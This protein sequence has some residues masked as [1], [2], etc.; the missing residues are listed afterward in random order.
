ME[1]S[2]EGYEVLDLIASSGMGKVYRARK[3][4]LDRPVAIKVMHPHMARD[5]SFVARFEREARAA[6]QVRHE[7]VVN[8]EDFGNVN[9]LPYLV[10]EFVEGKD[11]DELIA[12]AGAPPLELAC[13]VIL[14][15]CNGLEQIHRK[16]VVHR[17]L[18][19][20]NIMLSVTG[21]AKITDFGL[22]KPM[23][24]GDSDLT[25]VG[26]RLG[27]PAYM[28]PEQATSGGLVGQVSDVFSM[29]SVAY[30]LFAGKLAFPGE[31][32][33]TIMRMVAQREPEPLRSA[34]PEVPAELEALVTRMMEKDPGARFQEI[35]E[36]VR[37]LEGFMRSVGLH[38]DRRYMSRYVKDPGSARR[39][40]TGR[41]VVRPRG[42]GAPGKGPAPREPIAEDHDPEPVPIEPPEKTLRPKPP[43]SRAG[44][45]HHD[46]RTVVR[47]PGAE[48]EPPPQ[49]PEPKA[50]TGKGRPPAREPSEGATVFY[51]PGEG[52]PRGR[53]AERIRVEE[54]R[55]PGRLKHWL[56][57][58][59][60]VL[61]VVAA[62]LVIWRLV[63]RE[64]VSVVNEQPTS[65]GFL[66][67]QDEY[68]IP[69]GHRFQLTVQAEDPAG[70][71]LEYSLEDAPPGAV[72]GGRSGTFSWKPEA[73]Q[74][75]GHRLRF[76][77]SNGDE[78]AGREVEFLVS[79]ELARRLD[80][81]T[82]EI[83]TFGTQVPAQRGSRE[84]TEAAAGG[85]AASGEAGSGAETS[86]PP[87]PGDRP[88]VE[89][90]PPVPVLPTGTLV[91]ISNHP[92]RVLVDG[93][94]WRSGA[95]SYRGELPE[96]KYQVAVTLDGGVGF[97]EESVEIQEDQLVLLQP[98][99]TLG[100]MT[101]TD[102]VPGADLY[103]DGRRFG[104][105]ESIEDVPITEGN[106]RF[107]LWYQDRRV[108][109]WQGNIRE[110][111]EKKFR[112]KIDDEEFRAKLEQ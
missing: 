50:P 1:P 17:D 19:P 86:Q 11:L 54:A 53:G 109:T 45:G 84:E 55:Q 9:G 92:V 2:I 47:R 87:Q 81:E 64:E 60:A 56:A 28:S 77:V 33:L 58:S 6:A 103:V 110:G 98:K 89:N 34:N 111:R 38:V 15:A 10:M 57:L 43:P 83:S 94:A 7:N 68:T 59:G 18:K 22:A 3:I 48:A 105:S 26:T 4:S 16:G 30:E 65:L 72:I 99:F 79:E 32:P 13:M 93:K 36:V 35:G 27:T 52:P 20:G 67:L 5:P 91:V 97:Q 69:V 74:I 71:S 78:I 75:G 73:S 102:D 82:E 101:F 25:Q 70:R 95:D 8:V 31:D 63:S 88:P 44:R 24:G 112:P 80:E 106:H 42:E 23:E 66:N 85:E 40:L 62:A 49:P 39:E 14:D 61:V 100:S 76:R 46:G 41:T 21:V 104:P 96:G 29:G 108:G 90:A 12:Q 37:A 51:S 107:E